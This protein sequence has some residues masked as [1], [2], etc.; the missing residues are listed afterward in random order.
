MTPSLA[1]LPTPEPSKYE[2]D[3][4]SIRV[5]QVLSSVFNF[6]PEYVR[7]PVPIGGVPQSTGRWSGI[8]GQLLE[9]VSP[10]QIRYL[11]DKGAG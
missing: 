6:T 3:S 8:T 4:W 11:G 5:V 7:A 1:Q 2:P 9:N 10:S